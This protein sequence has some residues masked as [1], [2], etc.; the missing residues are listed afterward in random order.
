MTE[1]R[2]ASLPRDSFIC[3][4]LLYAFVITY[5][6]TLVGPMGINYVPM[7]AMEA[8]R[9]FL[10]TPYV[11]NGS[12]QRADW[13]GN[14]TM[15][16]PLGWLAA[17]AVWPRRHAALRFLA[18][19]LALGVCVAFVLGVKYLQLFFP[20]R[21]VT[22]NYILAQNLG[23]AAGVGLFWLTNRRLASLAHGWDGGGL[24]SLAVLLK[25]YT[26][27]LV[28]FMLMPLDFALSA[29]DL[30]YVLGRLPDIVTT[31]SGAGR[32][33]LIRAVLLVSGT[34][35]TVPIGM[36]LALRPAPDRD[37][38]SLASAT[39]LGFLAMTAVLVLSALLLS[40]APSLLA[41]GYRSLG[42]A[43]GAWLMRWLARQDVARLRWR[44]GRWVPLLA[45]VYLVAL[46]AVNG[47]LSSHW[48]SPMMA[49]AD[50]PLR[51][52]LPL[53]DYYIVTKAEAAKNI[54]AHAVMYA[55]VGVMVW[56]RARRGGGATAFILGAVLGLAVEAGRYMRPDLEGEIN[57]IGVAAI[58]AWLATKLMPA[59][60]WMLGGVAHAP[61]PPPPSSVVIGWRER[62]AAN[63]ARQATGAEAIGEIERF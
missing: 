42:I 24:S 13:M 32:P 51:H 63:Q 5:A 7:P 61:P 1:A 39:L 15:L 30:G 10:A 18:A 31:V 6:S 41:L 16:V 50:V 20:P 48:Q 28:L 12:D 35:A 3:W 46:A 2:S 33:P 34:A 22:L 57:A 19:P 62:A 55:P 38:R 45:A 25:L 4:T 49:L 21:T 11:L 23:S 52:F 58:S 27:A 59:V 60:W 56:L 8:L 9:R 43:A 29:E 40:G 37:G 47:L 17:G 54:V 53:F 36:L 26:A 14:L 44:L